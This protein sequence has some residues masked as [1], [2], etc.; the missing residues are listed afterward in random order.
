MQTGTLK[1][2][3][4]LAEKDESSDKTTPKKKKQWNRL[5]KIEKGKKQEQRKQNAER[6]ESKGK[7]KR[8]FVKGKK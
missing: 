4:L 7:G 2:N 1:P 8:A 6:A 5:K 3:C